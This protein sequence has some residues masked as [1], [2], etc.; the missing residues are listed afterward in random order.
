MARIRTIKP[1]AFTS[2][3]LS[4][5]PRGIRWTFAGLWTYADDEGR[6]RDDVRLIKAA[7]YP[8]DDDVALATVADDLKQLE[9]VGCICR[10][11]VAGRSYLHMPNWEHQKIN[12]P[13]PAKTPACPK[14]E[15]FVS[16]QP[17]DTDDSLRDHGGLSEDSVGE[18]KGREGKGKESTRAPRAKS[19][20]PDDWTGPSDKHR[21]QAT[22]LELSIDY[23]AERFLDSWRARGVK[24]KDPEAA[25]R[26]WLRQSA[27]WGETK[28]SPNQPAPAP[29]PAARRHI[30]ERVPDHIDTNDPIAYAQWAKE[31]TQ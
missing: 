7:L 31:A 22:Q 2:E 8:L 23:E 5:V 15:H 19:P 30:P 9:A 26:N 6:A 25:F 24:Y 11:E 4:Q 3:S 27:K 16:A 12:R 20:T 10:Y 14:Q 17:D 18:R 21:E 1:D 13:T 28:Y 29:S